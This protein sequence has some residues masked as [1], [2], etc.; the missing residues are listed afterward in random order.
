MGP[1]PVTAQVQ[2]AQ[3]IGLQDD[4]A[5][6]QV[7]CAL[8]DRDGFMWYGT[9]GGLSRWDGTEFQHHDIQ[10]GLGATVVFDLALD[11]DGTMWVGTD[12]GIVRHLH[13]SFLPWRADV[14]GTSHVR[15]ILLLP[16]SAVVAA[17]EGNGVFLL[18]RAGVQHLMPD[19]GLPSHLTYALLPF[20]DDVLIGTAEGM[21]CLRN[22]KV[23]RVSPDGM[24]V[25]GM[26]GLRD[27]RVAV[28][29]T[30]GIWLWDGVRL[31]AHERNRELPAQ[32]VWGLLETESALYASGPKGVA[33]LTHDRVR[34]LNSANGVLDDFAGI[35]YRDSYGAIQIA[36]YLAGGVAFYH[37]DRFAVY[38]STHGLAD[39]V[40]W[41]IGG[42]DAGNVLL[43]SYGNGLSVIRSDGRVDRY[44]TAD[45]LSD[46]S[47]WSIC[48]GG[49]GDVFLG[50]NRGVSVFRNHRVRPIAATLSIPERIY[51]LHEARDTLY[52][53]TQRGAW[54]LSVRSPHFILPIDGLRNN[55]ISSIATDRQG[56][57]YVGTDGDGLYVI[58]PDS[59]YWRNTK[60]GF[61]SD[62]INGMWIDSLGTV[63]IGT[64]GSGMVIV[65]R[66]GVETLGVEQ[67][68]TDNTIFGIV[69]DEHGNLFLSTNRGVHVL[70]PGESGIRLINRWDGMPSS[71][72]VHGALFVDTRLWVGTAKGV[73]A[74][75]PQDDPVHVLPRVHVTR[76]RIFEDDV[77]LKLLSPVPAFR[78]NE[79]YL[80]FDWVGIQLAA[81]QRVIYRYRLSGVDR[82]WVETD[83]RFVQ[84]S[85]LDDGEYRFEL[86]ASS[87]GGVWS[88]PKVFAFA[89]RPP[90]WETGWFIAG[91]V[92]L[93][94]GLVT[95]VIYNRIARFLAVEKLRTKIAADFHDQIGS[96]LTQVHMLAN[97]A[98]MGIASDSPASAHLRTIDQIA[99]RL[100]EEM[101]DIIWLIHPKKDSLLE[102]F[103][104]LKESQE[105]LLAQ[106]EIEFRLEDVEI[107][108]TVRMRM[109]FR[110]HLFLIFKE[111][112][113][114]GL[115]YSDCRTMTLRVRK[116]GRQL[117]V[118]YRDDGTGFSIGRVKL[119]NGIQN[120]QSR[121]A[122]MGGRLRVESAPGEGTIITY[123]GKV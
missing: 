80:K 34:V 116:T 24:L 50:T 14:L 62:K 48:R 58:G 119:G 122:A 111:A 110:Q 31:N 95:Y 112:M 101:R 8:E 121:A 77:N 65:R 46:N 73:F 9:F 51:A 113:H 20:G 114:N 38:K 41:S 28:G 26:I 5:Q 96:G 42:D 39:D 4:L 118:E 107:L 37:P 33:I 53:G 22:G 67:G 36:Q 103:T 6:S 109:E 29:T 15:D 55:V 11:R 21:A 81:P 123:E 98:T 102:L 49:S 7:L 87:G 68:L 60:T 91:V 32:D 120:M 23:E 100:Y 82:A 18:S 40:M 44:T 115:K 3:Y 43:G 66:S 106:Q 69:G 1:A 108:R 35:L 79:N 17:T 57:M 61:P 92:L 117:A 12:R 70:R 64:T 89:I 104:R 2:I 83:R 27:G 72:C 90:F 97:V 94:A 47:V 99:Q 52:I 105:E 71:E 86:T 19:D 76:L 30:R 13:G 25:H 75:R 10:S 74:C 78:Y 59:A 56:T 85:N 88:E 93:T 63:F 84:Y 16:D 45:G 54:K